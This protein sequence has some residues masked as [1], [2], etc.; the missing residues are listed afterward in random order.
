MVAGQQ[1]EHALQL[2]VTRFLER[3]LPADVPWTAVDHAAKLS[4]RQAGERKRRGVRRG[5]ADYRGL[6]PPSGRSW[7]IELKRAKGAYQSPEQKA[8]EAGVTAAGGLYAV[9]RSIPEVAGTLT[10]WGVRLK[11]LA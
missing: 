3:A 4:Q 8:W 1:S 6:L 9:C 2:D 11:V 10:G 7:E 5:Q